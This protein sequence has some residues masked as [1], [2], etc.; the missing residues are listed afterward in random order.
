MFGNKQF[1]NDALVSAIFLKETKAVPLKGNVVQN[2]S[3]QP[4]TFIKR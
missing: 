2:L 1:S 3:T 4:D